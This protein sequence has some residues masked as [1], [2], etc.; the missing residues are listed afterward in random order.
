MLDKLL[1]S[2]IAIVGG[3]NFCKRLLQLLFSAHFDDCRP[4]ILGVADINRQAEGWIYAKEKGIPT[5]EDYRELYALK[6]L[7][8]LMELIIP[9][10]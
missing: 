6:D 4:S 9:K 1:K 2:N 5:T 7:Q 3:G 10:Q 8:I